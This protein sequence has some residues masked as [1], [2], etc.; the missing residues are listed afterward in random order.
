VRVNRVQQFRWY[1]AI[2][3]VDRWT[4]GVD[5]F[6]TRSPAGRGGAAAKVPVG[7]GRFSG[8]NLPPGQWAGWAVKSAPNSRQI[9]VIMAGTGRKPFKTYDLQPF[10]FG[11]RLKPPGS[12]GEP[13]KR[14][15]LDLICR[16]PAGQFRES[17]LP[18]LCRWAEVT[19]MAE[20][21]AGELAAQG[22]VVDGKVSPWFSIHQQA[23]K[24]LGMLALRLHLAPQSRAHAAP[25]TLPATLSYY[26]RWSLEEATRDETHQ[27]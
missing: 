2:S 14:A 27:G 5:F 10:G 12:L 23:T 26:D 17:D 22:M 9:G 7:W 13:E 4:G 11:E 21:A 15:F 1:L 24:A 8:E 20:Q 16:V 18:L 3:H 25:K 6:K 19:I